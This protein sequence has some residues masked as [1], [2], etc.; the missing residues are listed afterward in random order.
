MQL[1][2]LRLDGAHSNRKSRRVGRGGKRGTT[3]GRGQKGQKSRSGH[4]I[5]PA[6]RDLI[7][8]LPKRRGFRNKSIAKK[9]ATLKVDDLKDLSGVIDRETL[10]KAGLIGSRDT[11]T[12]KILGEGEI[13]RAVTLKGILA[14]KTAKM[15]IEKAGGKIEP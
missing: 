15:K 14:S 4:R 6:I 10:M 2:N 13:S 9:A 5:R 11:R 8:R 3:S 7:I 1:H 12:I